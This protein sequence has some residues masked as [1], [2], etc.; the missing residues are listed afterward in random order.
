MAGGAVFEVV[1]A[2]SATADELHR[3]DVSLIYEWYYEGQ[4]TE[5]FGRYTTIEK[6]VH[7]LLT[8]LNVFH[9]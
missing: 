8:A 2:K 5:D 3:S 9:S 1:R 7:G 6:A 4:F